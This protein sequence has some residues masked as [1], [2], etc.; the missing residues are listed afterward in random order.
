MQFPLLADSSPV[1]ATKVFVELFDSLTTVLMSATGLALV[2]AM[3]LLIGI[4]VWVK[5]GGKRRS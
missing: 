1:D 4:V 3:V 5:K 2:F